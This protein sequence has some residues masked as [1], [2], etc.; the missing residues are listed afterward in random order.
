MM[1]LFKNLEKKKQIAV[2]L[3]MLVSVII[4]V[5]SV[6]FGVL[7]TVE[8]TSFSVLGS[9]IPG[10]IFCGVS[11]FLGYRYFRSTIKLMKKLAETHSSFELQNFKSLIKNKVR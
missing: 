5:L 6:V 7:F 2:L 10:V 1:T 3:L 4:V 8:G 11:A 9:G